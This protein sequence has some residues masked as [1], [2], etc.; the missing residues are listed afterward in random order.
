M[1]GEELCHAEGTDAVVTE[2]LGHL[3]VGGEVLL[4]SGVLEV[5]FLQV[6]PELLDAL[7]AAGLVLAD[8]GGEVSAELEG[9]GESGSLCHFE[10]V[11]G[12]REEKSR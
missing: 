10:F 2:D 8:D 6:G 3:L 4:V 9:L 12:V 5:V 7:R 11:F 1:R